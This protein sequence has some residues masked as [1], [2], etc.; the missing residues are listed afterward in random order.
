MESHSI[1]PQAHCLVPASAVHIVRMSSISLKIRFI[2]LFL[3]IGASLL[4]FAAPLSEL[5]ELALRNDQYTHILLMPPI[6]IGLLI[7][8][9]RRVFAHPDTSPAFALFLLGAAAVAFGACKHWLPGVLAND[10]TLPIFLIVLTWTGL[11]VL[12]LGRRVYSAGFF[13]MAMLFL[14]IPPPPA[15]MDFAVSALQKASADLSALM[16]KLTPVPV[17]HDGM[18]FALPGVEIEVARECSGIRSS[19]ALLIAMLLAS[20]LFLRSSSRQVLFVLCTL[21]LAVLKNAIRIVTLTLL[22]A[23]VS[24]DFLRGPVHHRG[25]VLFAV[26]VLVLALPL[27]LAMQR[28]ENGTGGPKAKREQKD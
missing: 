3:L 23:Y 18:K 6:C 27:L 20:H 7:F 8:E 2:S 5:A 12:V 16:F 25:G 24:P 21:P 10:G 22:G 1:G 19:V 28:S 15:F 26:P 11:F 13:P 17:F 9:R 14:M 4:A